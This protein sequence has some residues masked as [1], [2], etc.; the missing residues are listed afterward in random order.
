MIEPHGGR[1][2][3]RI[4]SERR[5]Q[6]L[7][8]SIDGPTI[9]LNKETYQEPVNIATGRYSPLTGFMDQADFLKVTADMSLE[10]GTVR[11]LPILLDIDGDTAASLTKGTLASLAS[12]SGELVGVLDV[13]GIYTYDET[14]AAEQIFGT[15]DTSHP[16]VASL[17]GRKD[18][19][20]GGDITLFEEDRHRS[21]D[22]FPA[23]TRVLFDH[24][25]WQSVVGFQT[26]NAPHRAH[27]YIQ[28]SALELVDGLLIQPKFGEKKTNDYRDDVIFGAYQTLI[29]HYYPADNVVISSFP[30]NMK[31]ARPRECV[32]DAIVRKN[33][34]C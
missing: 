2:I 26:R 12:P 8:D 27:E 16:G 3:D 31:Y 17:F 21:L 15:T 11:T 29:N 32:F 6:S 13:D 7:R 20:V 18:F 25:G 14:R 30:S 10:D 23:E 28:K 19:F 34:G 24:Y 5:A 1:L 33:H 22:L 9:Q 4:A